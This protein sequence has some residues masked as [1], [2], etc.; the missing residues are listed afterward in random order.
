MAKHQMLMRS[1]LNPSSRKVGRNGPER[2]NFGVEVVV[3]QYGG[4]A[5]E[6]AVTALLC[7]PK[8][9]QRMLGQKGLPEGEELGSNAL[10]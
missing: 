4:F 9:Q 3:A 1:I 10:R 6:A 8:S 5:R 2:K 7:A